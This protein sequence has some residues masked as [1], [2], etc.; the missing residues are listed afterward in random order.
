MALGVAG[1]LV[2][3][4]PCVKGVRAQATQNAQNTEAANSR[5]PGAAFSTTFVRLT[6]NANAL[7]YEPATTDPQ[8]NRFA[9]LIAHPDHVNNFNYFIA[10]ELAR[11][12]YRVMTM[13]YYG[14]EEVYDEFLAPLAAAVKYLRALPG[15]QKVV[16]AGHSTGGAELT[17][18]QDVAENGPK[19]CQG[20]ERVYP[21]RGE[22]LDKL[23]AADG[24]MII[25]SSAGALER[26]IA[27]DPSVGARPREHKADVDLFSPR[28]GFNPQIR[29]GTYSAE[30]ER[31]YFKAQGERQMRLIAQA[32]ARLAKIEKGEGD[33]KDDEPFVVPGSSVHTYDGAR[34]D[35][36]DLGI[37]S[38]THSPHML[39]RPDGSRPIQIIPSTRPG[40]AEADQ[41]DKL[42]AT[43]QDVTVRH[44]LTFLAIRT[45][46][47]YALTPDRVTG[48]EWRS[49]PNSIPG[50]VQGVHV[51]TL[52]MSGTCAPHLVF[53]EIAYELSAAK[54][55]D[56][57]GVEGGNHYFVAC[58][59]EYGDPAQHAFDYVDSW[60]MR[61]GRF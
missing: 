17:Y 39:L 32:Q 55:K 45:G 51:P 31:G 40:L 27:L 35:L 53:T 20:P 15:V 57:V 38:R 50:N 18:Y 28:N 24:V 16:L 43:T 21:C 25:D 6:N 60:L 4:A 46:P 19:A 48:V 29:A 26:L 14:P 56:F 54:D 13:N 10:P 3:A 47:D 23:P 5:R 44:F 1:L 34:I 9:V 41:M 11:R 12:G 8:R 59:P 42:D 33:Y 52:F 2:L 49:V 58:K 36:A 22:D 30:F 37:T 7:I 61:P